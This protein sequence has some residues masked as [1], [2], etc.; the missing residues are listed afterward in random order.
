MRGWSYREVGAL[1]ALR[2]LFA[3]LMV[4]QNPRRLFREVAALH[5]G[6]RGVADA[7]IVKEVGALQ[8]TRHSPCSSRPEDL[9]LGGLL[10]GILLYCFLKLG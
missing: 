2:R 9:V 6:D 10:L 4:L 5:N 8:M 3:E 7:T 1:R